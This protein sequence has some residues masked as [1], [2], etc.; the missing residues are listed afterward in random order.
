VYHDKLFDN[1]NEMSIANLKEWAAQMGM[2]A[3]SFNACLDKG[4][5]RQLVEADQQDGNR[6]GVSS[7]PTVFI[8]GR[9]VV[10]AVPIETYEEII[11]EELARTP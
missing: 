7:T 8:N 2:D 6:Y 4:T 5:H 9:A 10:G 11:R 3:P 1:Q